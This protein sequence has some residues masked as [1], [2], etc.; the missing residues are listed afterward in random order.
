MRGISK[1]WPPADVSPEGPEPR[2]FRDAE[3]EYLAAL[4]DAADRTSHARGE[5]DRMDKHKLRDVMCREQRSVC[6]YCERRVR[7]GHPAPRIDHWRP[8]SQSHDLASQV[9]GN[10]TMIEWTRRPE[11]PS[12]DTETAT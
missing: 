2:S 1:P 10:G 5:F 7:E 6:A 11:A 4:P 9:A 12:N 3:R 8:L